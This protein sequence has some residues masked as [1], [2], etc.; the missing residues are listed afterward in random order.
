MNLNY[1]KTILTILLSTILLS[2]QAQIISADAS[3]YEVKF[4]LDEIEFLKSEVVSNPL[5]IKNKSSQPT[6]ITLDVS[7]PPNWRIIGTRKNEVTIP[8]N[9][10][11]YIPLRFIPA[12]GI[13][14]NTKYAIN[15]MIRN[16]DGYPVGVSQFFCFTKKILKWEMEIGPADKI[17][18]RNDE[19]EADF[20]LTLKNTGNQAA[21]FQ[22]TLNG[23]TREDLVLRD[24]LGN[25]IRRPTYTLPLKASADTT[26][27]FNVS[28]AQFSRNFR[29]VSLTSHRPLSI[30]QERR[31]RYYAISE[32]AKDIDGGSFKRGTKMD[33]VRLANE[34]EVSPY[35]SDHL[36]LTVEA[37]V[38]NILSD[39]SIMSLNLMG[40]KQIDADSRLVYFT[41]FFF[42][43][44]FFNTELLDNVPWYVG[45]FEPKWDVQLGMVN[46]RAIGTPSAGKGITGSYQILKKH[47]I[48][49][50]LTRSPNL[51]NGRYTNYGLFHEYEGDGNF[52]VTSSISRSQDD[53]LK[54]DINVIST[55]V[56]KRIA[57]GHNISLMGAYSYSSYRDTS[58]TH[59]GYRLGITYSGSMIDRR[60]RE[61]L[62]ARYSS[63]RFGTSNS[64]LISINNRTSYS[65]SQNWD[66]LLLN[67]FNQSKRY[68]MLFTDST[69]NSFSTFTNR[70]SFVTR[71]DVG[72]FQPGVY[73]DI[74][75][76]P[77]F[78]NHSRGIS[79]NYNKFDFEKNTLFTTTI[80]AGY[81]NPLNFPEIK[82]YFT[83]RWSMLARVRTMTLNMR[84]MYGP[85]NPLM[86][87]TVF[88]QANYP[89]Q[90]RASLQHQYMFKNTRFIVQSSGSYAYNNQMKSH[91]IGAF[92]ELFYFST[93]GWRFS[94][95][96]Q[97]SWVSSDVRG[98]TS[99]LNENLGLQLPDNGPTTSTAFRVGVTVRKEFGI[100][101]PFSKAKNHD[102][103]VLAFYD[104]NGNGTLD[105]DEPLIENVVVRIGK[106]EVITNIKGKASYKNLPQGKYGV[107][108]IPLDSPEG[109]FPDVTDSVDIF[110]SGMFYVPFV[111]GIKVEG[112][113]M[114]DLDKLTTGV[115]EAFDLSHI[116]IT[117]TNGKSYH[118]LTDVKGNFEFYLPNGGYTITLDENVLTDKYRL[119]QNDIKVKLSNDLENMFITFM[120]VEKRRKVN[121]KKFGVE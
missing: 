74:T 3:L 25:I 110:T 90:F 58:I 10:S 31:F 50:H 98:V 66:I 82:E 80:Q 48:G 108:I 12:G 120:V 22:V 92:P 15:A 72:T 73:Y 88:A 32:E 41:Q 44:N 8:A 106:E 29:T 85:S 79:F 118:T 9:D 39:Y 68:T 43:Q 19:D 63:P 69:Q 101:I 84:Y 21:D 35:G 57:Q 117:A 61:N 11:I 7:Y 26:L 49:A 20:D 28:P 18:F 2:T 91:S 17:Y 30:T 115:N 37:Q 121:V 114:I 52:R 77:F 95:R 36:P 64:E 67:N 100:P 71:T 94:V 40:A 42:S 76:Q 46:G 5:M 27:K 65:L 59:D 53:Q 62:S 86:L 104:L 75:E 87:Q 78:T 45:Y 4:K 16:T 93:T 23:G 34:N 119:M 81:N 89:K 116:K 83:A 105:N 6:T 24:T 56:S 99:S 111:R 70:L 33:F 96:T 60:L 38:Q 97:Y 112:Q 54:R 103:D 107:E 13:G 51:N 109:W 113:V 102:T 1:T 47:R 55:R 14:G